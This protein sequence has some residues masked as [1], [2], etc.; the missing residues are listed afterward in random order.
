[1]LTFI[2]IIRNVFSWLV[3]F[4]ADLDEVIAAGFYFSSLTAESVRKVGHLQI[5]PVIMAASSPWWH[6]CVFYFLPSQPTSTSWPWSV[7]SG[8]SSKA[9]SL[10]FPW[11]TSPGTWHATS[12]CQIISC[13]RWS[14]EPNNPSLSNVSVSDVLLLTPHLAALGTVSC[15]R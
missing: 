11:C 13:L 1:M 15:G 9:S 14:S 6:H 5:L 4:L 3:T 12:K 7:T 10:W 8:T 2:M